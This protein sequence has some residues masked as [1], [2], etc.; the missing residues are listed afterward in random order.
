MTP[1]ALALSRRGRL[2]AWGLILALAGCAR[3]DPAPLA[4]ARKRLGAEVSEAAAFAAGG[5]DWIAAAAPAPDSLGSGAVEVALLRRVA[6]EWQ[7]VRPGIYADASPGSWGLHDGDG[8]SS[9]EVWGRRRIGLAAGAR[10]DVRAYS[11]GREQLYRLVVPL[12]G[13][14]GPDSAQREFSFNVMEH[15]ALQEWLTRL[16]QR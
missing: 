7:V 14:S 11:P 16:A 5:A 15:P 10:V 13:G 12:R 9:P 6:G 4:E 3:D 2:F 1:D 8:D